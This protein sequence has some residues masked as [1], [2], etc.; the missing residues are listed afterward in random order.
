MARLA[1]FVTAVLLPTLTSACTNKVI[2]GGQGG[3]LLISEDV[4]ETWVSIDAIPGSRVYSIY[5]VNNTISVGSQGGYAVSKD[6]GRTWTFKWLHTHGWKVTGVYNDGAQFYASVQGHNQAWLC[7]SNDGEWWR[8]GHE[9]PGGVANTIYAAE[10]VSFV[11]ASGNGLLISGNN[12]QTWRIVGPSTLG[13]YGVAAIAGQGQTV[14]VAL[15]G[16]ADGAIAISEDH[17]Q[18]WKFQNTT[19]RGVITPTRGW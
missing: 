19:Q 13:G 14:Y 2:V 9:I 15:R 5:A 4:G 12:G 18:T 3:Q 7:T 6:G 8:T 11:G 10:G 1:F 17:G 16:S